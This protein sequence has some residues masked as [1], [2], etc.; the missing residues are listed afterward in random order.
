MV[1]IGTLAAGIAIGFGVERLTLR[2]LRGSAKSDADGIE[3]DESGPSILDESVVEHRLASHDGGE[4]RLIEAGEGH[5]IVLLHGVTLR[6]SVW[7]HQF[8]LADDHRVFAVD[9]RAH[10]EST[11][12]SDGS[13]LEANARDLVTILEHFD[14][15]NATIVGHSMGGMILGRFLVD[16][17][18][19]VAER[20]GSAGFVSSAGRNPARVPTGILAPLS[21]RLGKVARKHPELAARIAKVPPSDLGEIAVRSTFGLA[22]HPD[23]VREAALAFEALPPEDLLAIAPSIF[24][25]DVL[26]ELRSVD[27]PVGITVGS[28]DP[29]TEPRESELLAEAIDGSTLEVLADA[30]HQLMLERPDEVNAFIVEL[31]ARAQ[32]DV[33]PDPA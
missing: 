32:A 15:H 21:S 33:R 16:H 23:D 14:L 30:G 2:K 22:A 17:P 3:S 20:V 10:G 13:T 12:G 9:L 27:L 5:P 8:E 31:V 24:A 4:I 6:A 26:D 7:H 11:P 19:V 29:M 28:R 1:K 25:H 18:E